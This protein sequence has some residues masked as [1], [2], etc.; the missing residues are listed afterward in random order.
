MKN[1]N[2]IN[3]K[4]IHI[5]NQSYVPFSSLI[6]GYHWACDGPR[7]KYGMAA[8]AKYEQISDC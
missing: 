5:N 8:E 6:S 3:K 4:I 1:R 7:F 2:G